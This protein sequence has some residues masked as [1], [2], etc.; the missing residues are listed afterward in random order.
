MKKLCF[1]SFLFSLQMMLGQDI[2]GTWHGLLDVGQ[3]LRLD[4]RI[5][6]NGEIYE[7]K[8]DSP[9][10]GAKD[11]RATKVEFSNNTL[12]FEVKNLGINY[13]GVLTKDS[14]NGTF[15]QNGF[16]T[17]LLLSRAEVI[18]K[19]PNRPQEPKAPFEYLEEEVLF[20]NK[21]EKFNLAGTLTYPKGEG[22]FPAVILVS[23]SGPQDR[24]GEI[25]E[26]KPF[27]I[28]A[29]YLTKE[30]FAVLRYDDRGTARSEGNFSLATSVELSQDAES[31]LDFL[32]AN[33]K[34]N[35]SKICITGHS[36]GAMIAVMLAARRKDIHSIALL[37]GPAI[38]G[39]ELLLLQ[40]YLINKSNGVS[41][42]NNKEMIRY[43]RK[44][45]TLLLEHENLEE[46]RPILEK[47]IRKTLKKTKDRDLDGYSSKEALIQGVLG[48]VCNPWMFY[49]I[50]YNPKSDLK[51]LDCHVL[52]LNGSMDLQV[53]PKEN[54]V[55][56]QQFIPKSDKSQ[57]FKELPNLNH[58]FQECETGNPAEY[59]S[60]EQTIEPEVLNIM[61]DW[62]KSIQNK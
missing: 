47:K 8:L 6:K 22:P 39:G 14:I 18:V 23:G 2:T 12:V 35:A 58:L 20:E 37:A 10:Q 52:A 62:L 21:V 36:E 13:S 60:I 31:A 46:V 53:P 55:A 16:S 57:V 56:M 24:N 19:K 7:G 50:K 49:F 41:D 44:I 43:N 15:K 5:S 54:L 25:L 33:T 34:I 27:W 28:I 32:K 61:R 9:D 51:K 4:L 1:F 48:N 40:Q 26:H 17:K 11:I 45:Y 38:Q 30:G 29:D 42:K 59:G 3:K